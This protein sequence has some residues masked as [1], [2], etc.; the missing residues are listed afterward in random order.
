[1]QNTISAP[2]RS[3]G[4]AYLLWFFL[5]ALGAHKFYL[6]RPGVGVLYALTF[7]L[8]GIGVLVDLFTLP[9][10]VRTSNVRV[11]QETAALT[12]GKVP[13]SLIP[14]K[15]RYT[16]KQQLVHGSV[17]LGLFLVGFAVFSYW[18]NRGPG[19]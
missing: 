13:D 8:L 4:T 1:M 16:M 15:T 10:Q 2:L 14:Q 19:I 12:G 7:G 17:L 3:T 9:D 18:W 11:I 5:G 6:G